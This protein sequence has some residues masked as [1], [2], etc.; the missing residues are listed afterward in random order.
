MNYYNIRNIETGMIHLS[1][2]G[3]FNDVYEGIPVSDYSSLSGKQK[4]A[5]RIMANVVCF[6]ESFDNSLMW[7]HYADSHRGLCVEYDTKLL[8]DKNT[9]KKIFPVVYDSLRISNCE[10]N[11]LSDE[12]IELWDD[13]E[14]NNEHD[15][16]PYL[17]RIIPLL[18]K[19]NKVWEYEKEWRLI[20]TLPQYY[21][22]FGSSSDWSN[23]LLD[24]DCI[25]A[26]YCGVRCD[27]A[28]VKDLNEIRN[29]KANPFRLYRSKL[30]TASY[31][32]E[33]EEV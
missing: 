27:P 3:M 24:F 2:I 4:S 19:K 16:G 1:N 29:R 6:S 7:S 13:L 30:S 8:R 25:T 32:I 23:M 21:D 18:L 33:F 15:E 22:D 28:V 12:L 11:E 17:R 20:Y 9:I 26:V 14:K 10:I 31:G 5:L